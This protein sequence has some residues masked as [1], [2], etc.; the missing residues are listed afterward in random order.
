MSM[1]LDGLRVVELTEALAGPYYAMLLGDFGAE[2]TKVERP[3][4]TD[5][6][7]AAAAPP[8]RTQSRN[9]QGTPI[10][11]GPIETRLRE[12]CN[13]RPGEAQGRKLINN[14]IINYLTYHIIYLRY[15][16]A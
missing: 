12:A 6:L 15:T 10:S 8:G 7:P 11:G 2:V 13:P 14:L 3:G 5:S 4:T 9:S 1:L 16:S